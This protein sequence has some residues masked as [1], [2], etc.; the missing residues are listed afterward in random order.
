MKS[1][2]LFIA[3]SL[4]ANVV[5]AVALLN[6][7]AAPSAEPT[8]SRDARAE[9]SRV[10]APSSSSVA[11]DWG[12]RI[13]FAIEAGDEASVRR[14]MGETGLSESAAR[15]LLRILIRRPFDDRRDEIYAAKLAAGVPFWRRTTASSLDGLTKGERAELQQLERRARELSRTLTGLS[16]SEQYT[17]ARMDFL[18]SAKAAKVSDLER[19]YSEMQREITQNM[20]LFSTGEDQAK[21]KLLKEERER[22]LAALLSPEE[23]LLYDLNNSNTSRR[24]RTSLACFNATEE[25]FK[26]LYALQKAFDD[27]YSEYGNSSYSSE[28]AHARSKDAQQLREEMKAALGPVRSAEYERSQISDYKQLQAAGQRFGLSSSATDLAWSAR[29]QAIAA[30]EQLS[31][32]TS[33]DAEARKSALVN[34]AN[35]TRSS[36]TAALGPTVGAAY[37]KNAMNWLSHL[38]AGRPVTTA[39][40]NSSGVYISSQTTSA[41]TTV[42]K[43]VT[44]AQPSSGSGSTPS[45]KSN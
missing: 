32:D 28:T 23:R 14:L 45:K 2:H 33:L 12:A 41:G 9:K 13:S 16:D 30:A 11:K 22:D 43:V 15:A 8:V 4:V 36:V 25:E 20:M 29:E 21:L 34:I 39:M 5:L 17:Q 18:P 35:Q 24:L 42:T 6:R 10:A 38:D 37:L 44:A 3:L 40:V 27:K 26:K 1:S 19:D 31:K 7:P